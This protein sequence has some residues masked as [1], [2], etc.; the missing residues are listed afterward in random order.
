[1]IIDHISNIEQYLKLNPYF[2]KA[3]AFLKSNLSAL[4]IGKQ[5]IDGD[6]VFAF[7]VESE[8]SQNNQ[9]E[10]HRKYIDIHFTLEGVDKLA[11]RT[12]DIKKG[13][14]EGDDVLLFK[15]D[16]KVVVE[17]PEQ[18]FCICF[19][20]DAHIPLYNTRKVKKMI[21]KVAIT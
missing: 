17:I 1:M 12:L 14:N 19:P 2:E 9:F 20:K 4:N 5:E 11:W 3:F 7:V 18:H 10:A 21:I 6:K 15:G 16:P 8:N 13:Y